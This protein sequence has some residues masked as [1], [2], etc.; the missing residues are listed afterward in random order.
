MSR[1]AGIVIELGIGGFIDGIAVP[2]IG[3]GYLR[4]ERDVFST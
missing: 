3:E 1:A 4:R 2:I